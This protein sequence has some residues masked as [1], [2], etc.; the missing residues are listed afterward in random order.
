[1]FEFVCR[2]ADTGI[3]DGNMENS[4]FPLPDR[5]FRRDL[6]RN[7][8]LMSELNGVAEQVGYDLA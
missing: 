8:A 6:K 2:N 7:R 1:M 5:R 4:L 3:L